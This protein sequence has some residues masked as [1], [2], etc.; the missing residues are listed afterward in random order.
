MRTEQ[1]TS[2]GKQL[3]QF[4]KTDAAVEKNDLY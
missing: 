1:K 2:K 3:K 4:K